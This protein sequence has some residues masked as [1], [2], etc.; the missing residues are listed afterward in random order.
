[1]VPRK[2]WEKLLDVRDLF[3]KKLDVDMLIDKLCSRGVLNHADQRT[4]T[5]IE[6]PVKKT[7]KLLDKL[8]SKDAQL[9]PTFV[10]ALNHQQHFLAKKL[11][12][13]IEPPVETME[14]DMARSR[15]EPTCPVSDGQAESPP[16]LQSGRTEHYK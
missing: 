15:D 7:R 5:S 12:P 16:A 9:Y 14:P 2:D 1:M 8:Y 13:D 10:D 4:L 11:E 3:V 6:D